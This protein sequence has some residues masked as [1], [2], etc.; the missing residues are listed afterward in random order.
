MPTFLLE[1]L[2]KLLYA[3]AV[4]AR[5]MEL[6]K[7]QEWQAWATSDIK[8]SG[9]AV[10]HILRLIPA[11]N[12]TRIEGDTRYIDYKGVTLIHSPSENTWLI[13]KRERVIA[14]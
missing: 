1:M 2:E 9:E 14:E 11:V 8:I 13:S 5:Y 7:I 3:L 10:N 4:N 12:A 6:A